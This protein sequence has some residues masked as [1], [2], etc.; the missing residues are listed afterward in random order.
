MTASLHIENRVRDYVSWKEVFDKF[1]RFR[2]D[3]G[4][5]GHRVS[6][7]VGDPHTVVIDL[8]FD[9]TADAE[10]FREKLEKV[11]ASP[12]SR[13]ELTAHAVAAVHEVVEQ[14]TG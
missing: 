5:R 11:W 10:A 4:V 6:R 8:D 2:T 9:T 3:G 13:E 7:P 1:D 12:Q 14:L